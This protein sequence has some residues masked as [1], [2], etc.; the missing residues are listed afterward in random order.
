MN[1]KKE[2][3]LSKKPNGTQK[4]GSFF[5]EL[6]ACSRWKFKNKKKSQL[7]QSSKVTAYHALTAWSYRKTSP[8]KGAKM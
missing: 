1:H 2:G 7:T 4:G 8:K 5:A 3:Q 6:T